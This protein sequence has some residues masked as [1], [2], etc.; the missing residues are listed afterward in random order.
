MVVVVAAVMEDSE[1]DIA[2]STETTT[3]SAITSTTT[4]AS[5]NNTTT[6]T[7][8]TIV[9]YKPRPQA[10]LSL[11]SRSYAVALRHSSHCLLH[12]RRTSQCIII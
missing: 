7:T 9:V 10:G 12:H 11:L 4:S 5:T 8:T 3:I 2:I 1:M 6:N